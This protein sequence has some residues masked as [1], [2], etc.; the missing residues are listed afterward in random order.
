MC[1]DA[2]EC[3]WYLLAYLIM[4]VAPPLL[5]YWAWCGLLR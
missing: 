2:F 5:L 1:D 4:M 3:L